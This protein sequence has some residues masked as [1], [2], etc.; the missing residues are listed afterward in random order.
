MNRQYTKPLLIAA[1]IGAIGV[2]AAGGVWYALHSGA[3]P[4]VDRVAAMVGIKPR[5]T[6]LGWPVSIGSVAGN[7]SA[8]FADGRAAQARFSDPFGMVIDRD[9]NLFVADAG[10]NNRI[11]RITPEG[12]VSTLAGGKEGFADGNGGAAAFHTPSGM[13][14]D[15]AGNLYVAD[16]GNNAIRKVTP[17]GVVSTLA[18]GGVPGYLDG[19]ADLA[20]FNGP[21][22][23]AVDQAGV[24]YV[25]DTY[26]DRIRAIGTDGMVRTIAGST[27][28]YVDGP[29]GAALFDTPTSVVVDA[30]G[31]LYVADTSNGAVRKLAPDGQ[32]STVA[33][34]PEGAEKPLLRRPVALALTHDGFLYVG[35]IWRGR[36][37]Q[38]SPDGVLQGLTGIGVDIEVGDAQA[39]RLSRPSAIAIDRAGGLYVSDAVRRTVHR[40]APRGDGASAVL[41]PRAA[42]VATAAAPAGE[43]G[44][45][46]VA[47]TA[48]APATASAT[49]P[50]PVPASQAAASGNFPWPFKPQHQ[51]H[52]VVGTIGE[53]R[54][55]YNG[56]SRHHFHSGLDVQA[57]MG[58]PV[59]AVADEKV[60]S[61]VSNWAFGE[62]G[63]GMS[64]D[65]MAY[66]H[67]RVGRT[68]KDAPLDPARFIMLDNEKGKPARMRVR[69]GTRFHVGDALGTVNRMYHV[70]LVYQPG[71][72]EANPM[73]LPF[74]GFSDQVAPR[75]D[76]IQLVDAAG[77][78]L[79][80]K[81]GKRVV[82]ARGAGPLGIVVDAYDQ[83]DGNA[84]RRKLGLYKVGYQVLQAD[85]TPVAGFGKP[86]VNIEF[87]KLPPDPES[88]KL[89]YADNSGITVYG[90]AT[91][92]FLY[93]VTNTVRDG[94]AKSGGWD[95]AALAPGDYVIRIFAA[96]YAGNEALSGRELPITVE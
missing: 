64:I 22:G 83:A 89:A 95:P 56:E 53:V 43:I 85:G 66:I 36:I 93:V 13:A 61:P 27:P 26:N 8:G 51:R 11:R 86:L 82:V 44:A 28:G 47:A 96:D 12:V 81:P 17:Q 16:T 1:V 7:G 52:E 67:M 91:T 40:V 94:V 30:K 29:A 63:E 59:L 58:V 87:N 35:D 18:G 31:N 24:V 23:V 84:A 92:R 34:A 32:V 72:V 54:G 21:V 65:S 74:T 6:V 75:I 45:V 77:T 60:S 10:D 3:Q 41:A 14:I 20:M 62:V 46:P 25:A 80:R 48:A 49:L 70:H 88:V 37:L 50:V 39:V 71:G 90:S 79:A 73:V 33:I 69:R 2:C 38:L 68:G 42:P 57:D 78:A 19:K 4:S 55:S 76:K 9:G 5:P 15:A